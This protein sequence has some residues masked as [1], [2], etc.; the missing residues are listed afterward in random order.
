MEILINVDVYG[1][2]FSMKRYMT[3][4]FNKPIHVLLFCYFLFWISLELCISVHAHHAS[5]HQG[6]SRRIHQLW[7]Y[8]HELSCLAYHSETSNEG[9]SLTVVYFEIDQNKIIVCLELPFASLK[10]PL[11]TKFYQPKIRN[12][13]LYGEFYFFYQF[14]I[15]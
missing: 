5:G 12:F 7:R 6:Q 2:I 10:Y 1:L 13:F 4:H 11:L 3:R 9:Q 14:L 15:G 8:S